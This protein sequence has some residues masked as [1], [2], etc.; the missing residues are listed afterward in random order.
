MTRSRMAGIKVQHP[1]GTWRLG[2]RQCQLVELCLVDTSM[3]D[4]VGMGILVGM[5]AIA[6]LD[7]LRRRTLVDVH[8]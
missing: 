2:W 7:A 6:A 8:D 3:A 1:A 4:A 5:K